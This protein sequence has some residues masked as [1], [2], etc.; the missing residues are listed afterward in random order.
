M[1]IKKYWKEITVLSIRKGTTKL[2]KSKSL[3]NP[4]GSVG[5]L[6]GCL[7]SQSVDRYVVQCV[8]RLVGQLYSKILRQDSQ[9]TCWWLIGDWCCSQTEYDCNFLHGG[10]TDSWFRADV[11]NS[12]VTTR[13]ACC[14]FVTKVT[15]LPKGEQTRGHRSQCSAARG[16]WLFTP[17]WWCGALVGANW[18][19]CQSLL[20]KVSFWTYAGARTSAV[21]DL[22]QRGSM[23][24]TRSRGKY[25]RSILGIE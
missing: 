17:P 8:S 11:Q 10:D 25:L 7:V 19:I 13:P 9:M 21:V 4:S 23:L 22:L 6:V 14:C 3:K 1:Y 12:D 16:D 2:L 5:W 20:H 24:H 18:E 15:M